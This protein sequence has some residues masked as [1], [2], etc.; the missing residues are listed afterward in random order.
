MHKKDLKDILISVADKKLKEHNPC[1]FVKGSCFRNRK[2]GRRKPGCCDD[3][4]YLG[5]NGCTIK[6][7]GCKLYLCSDISKRD[8]EL[9][10]YFNALSDIADA[11]SL[12]LAVRDPNG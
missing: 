9:S 5:A 2:Q 6:C 10:A 12:L 11:A 1:D 4:N 7:L 3:C 8:L